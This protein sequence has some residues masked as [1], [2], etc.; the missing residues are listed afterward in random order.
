[1]LISTLPAGTAAGLSTTGNGAWLSVLGGSG[2]SS[3]GSTTFTTQVTTTFLVTGIVGGT[4]LG[5]SSGSGGSGG[6]GGGLTGGS[7]TGG[8]GGYAPQDFT[9][10]SPVVGGGSSLP[11][12]STPVGGGKVT[13]EVTGVT[14]PIT[15]FKVGH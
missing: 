8:S 10:S 6:A 13:T 5:S 14:N 9:G 7:S 15:G 11:F 2:Q 1:M 3:L 4:G 12:T